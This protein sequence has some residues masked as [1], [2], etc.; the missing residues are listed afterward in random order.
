MSSA[1]ERY[2]ISTRLAIGDAGLIYKATD[3]ASGR[4]VVLKLLLPEDQIAHPLDVESLLRDAPAIT[5]MTGA[6][7]VH[8]LEAFQDEDGMVLVYEFAEGTRG[9][10]V[11]FVCPITAAQSVEVAAQLLAALSCGELQQYPHGDLKPSDILLTHLPNGRPYLKVLDWGLANYRKEPTPGAL[12]FTAPERLAG[13]PPSHGADLFSAGALLF[14]L[15]SGAQPVKG[16]SKE[17]FATAWRMLNP[18]VLHR[19]RPDLPSALINWIAR[20]L[21][22]NPSE[23][24]ASAAAALND[25]SAF[26]APQAVSA[27]ENPQPSAAP[28]QTHAASPQPR[29][30]MGRALPPAGPRPNPAQRYLPPP[31]K[32]PSSAAMVTS[33]VLVLVLGGGGFALWQFWQPENEPT[34]ANASAE[35][36]TTALPTAAQPTKTA[37]P[38]TVVAA[39]PVKPM[40]KAAPAPLANDTPQKPL[41]APVT[42]ASGLTFSSSATPPSVDS[43]DIANL[44]DQTGLDKWFYGGGNELY[45]ADAAKGLTFTTGDTPVAFTA[46]TYKLDTGSKKG[47]TIEKPTT[48]TIRLGTLSG[49]N[50]TEITSQQGD[51]VAD[52]GAGDYITWKFTTP[53]PLLANTTYAV[54]AAMNSQTEWK[55][56]I[57]YLAV[58]TNVT[59]SGVGVSYQSGDQGRGATTIT[60]AP[61]IDRIFHVDLGTQ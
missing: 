41:S 40:E 46:L 18:H 17:E 7:I 16:S 55:T 42:G 29:A 59:T 4:D 30:P 14:Y 11:P 58:S 53:V 32:K 13:A 44:T 60:P 39:S 49:N 34:L 35:P 33:I 21:Q 10:D 52:T 24:P 45:G 1:A 37:A 5:L 61:A 38:P 19:L 15:F 48:W 25:L 12:P 28:P 54:D 57:P 47:A 8:L 9:L 3:R 22:A 56:G 43:A 50:F 23:R 2:D 51:Q 36:A 27:A 31:Q 26:D 20:L 6:N